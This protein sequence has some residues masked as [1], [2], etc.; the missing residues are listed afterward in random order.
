MRDIL[1]GIDHLIAEGIVVRDGAPI[2]DVVAGWHEP[3]AGLWNSLHGPNA[4]GTNPWVVAI[5][6]TVERRNIDTL[7]GAREP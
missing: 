1:T 6:F 2:A 7:P 4:W 5:S 3:F